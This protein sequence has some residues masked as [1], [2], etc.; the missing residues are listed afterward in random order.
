M[1]VCYTPKRF[2]PETLEVIKQA[3]GIIEDYQQQGYMLTLRQLYY[4]FVARD[5]VANTAKSYNRLGTIINDARLAGLV[6]WEAIE[7]RTRNL[8]AAAH[9][10]GPNDIVE[11]C[12]KQYRID[13]WDKQPYHLE[14]W[15]E[16]EALIGVFERVC[17]RNDI[18]WFA[19]R[20]YVSQSEMWGAAQ[21][22]NQFRKKRAC[23][24]LHFGDHDPSGIDMTRDIRERLSLFSPNG[25]II[26]LRLALTMEQVDRYKPPPN[27]AK[28]A[29]SRFD[30]YQQQFGDESWEL[31]ALEPAVLVDLVQAA[32]DEYRDTE[33]WKEAI[34]LESKHREDLS[35]VAKY[36]DDV[37]GI[38]Q[39][40]E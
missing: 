36:W 19:C 32:V 29:D 25:N 10:N 18:A 12:A 22:L 8:Q 11:A 27:P 3:N 20:G 6:D 9:W 33:A 4:Q 17:R 30:S 39:E 21:R 23:I 34:L 28:V 40:N 15:V 13:K 26:V 24:I 38:N 7:D 35:Y 5:L 14:V 16:K 31:D 1:K 2:K 37:I